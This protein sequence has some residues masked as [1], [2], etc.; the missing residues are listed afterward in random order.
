MLIPRAYME[1]TIRQ[2]VLEN[3]ARH[4]S[5]KENVILGLIL[6]SHPEAKSD[7]VRVKELISSIVSAV[8]SM[9]QEQAAKKVD[10]K[11]VKEDEIKGPLKPLPE[12]SS[13]VFRIAPSPSGPLHIGHAFGTMINFTYKQ[14]YNGKLILRIEDTNPSNIYPKAYDLIEQDA[15]WVTNNGIDQVIIQSDR[16]DLYYKY[17]RELIEKGLAYVCS[18][19]ADTWREMKAKGDES[20]YRNMDV[21]TQIERYERMFTDFAEGEAVIKFKTDMNHKNPAMRDFPIMRVNEHVH[22]RTGKSQRVWPLMVFSVAIDDHLLGVTH[23]LNGKD[24]ADNAK[25]EALI[26]KAFGW[27]APFYKHWGRINFLDIKLSTS[28][29]RRAIERNEYHGWDDVRLNTLLALKKRGYHPN[30]FQRFSIETGLSLTDKTVSK[31]EFWKNINA[32]NKQEIDQDVK[33]FFFVENPIKITV[34][35]APSKTVHLPLHPEKDIGHRELKCNE[36]YYIEKTDYERMQ[37]GKVYRFIDN[38]NVIYTGGKL[39]F[40]SETFEEYKESNKGFVL[41]WLPQKTV[42][43]TIKGPNKEYTGLAEEALSCVERP[44]IVQFERRFFAKLDDGKNISGW[45]LH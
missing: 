1:K 26:M 29:T 17:A 6:R 45:F 15:K 5:V 27:H 34:D 13:Y 14:M 10:L 18:V 39:E 40:H 2:L 44:S 8:S 42:G 12:S 23:V 3:Y 35:N 22:P 21:T 25:K 11:E 30:T 4:G 33:R 41:H 31:T 19:D 16:L 37:A 28:E 9:T 32:F 7:V 24:H 20:P 43:V 38:I 36:E